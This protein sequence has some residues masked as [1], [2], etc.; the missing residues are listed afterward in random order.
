MK[1]KTILSI[2]FIL[3]MVVVLAAFFIVQKPDSMTIVNGLASLIETVGL[4]FLFT[5]AGTSIGYII[6]SRSSLLIE[7]TP[8]LLIFTGI[9]MGILGLAGFGLAVIGQAHPILLLIV[10]IAILTLAIVNRSLF[11]AGDDYRQLI[12]NLK[13]SAQAAQAWIPWFA[14]SAAALTFLL[15]LAPP[16][17]AFDALSYHLTVPT[18][19]LNNGGVQSVNLLQ[20]WFPSLME[21]MFVWPLAFGKDSAPQLIHF[22]FALLTIL[23]AWDWTRTLWSPKAAW[24]TIAIF[25]SMPSLM[26]LAAWAYSDLALA[27]Y[28]LSALYTLWKWRMDSDQRWLIICGAML[29]FAMGIK[30]TSVILLIAIFGLMIGWENKKLKSLVIHCL[31]M[32]IPGLLIASPWYLRNWIWMGNAFYPFIFGGRYWDTFRASW[33]SS[34]GTGIGWNPLRILSLPFVATLGYRDANYFDG[35]FGPFYLILFP[36]VVWELLRMKRE[37]IGRREALTIVLIFSALSVLFWTYGVIQTGSLW[38]AR[39]LWPGIIP[40]IVPMSVSMIGLEKIDVTKLRFSFIFSVL[41]ELTIFVF[42]LDFGLQVLSRDPLAVAIGLESRESYSA[43]EQPNYTGAVELV[44]QTPPNAYIY[45]I[46]EPRSYGMNRHIQ[47]DPINDNLPHDFYL[48]PANDELLSAWHELGYTHILLS[49][50]IMQIDNSDSTSLLIPGFY[51][52]LE[53]L[54]KLLKAEGQTNDGAYTLYSIPIH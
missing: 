9:G 11:L 47:P 37:Q 29:G 18:W 19:W 22:V 39:L 54:K 50:R 21:G 30:Y 28:S 27:F 31:W 42:L 17:E 23:M 53:N 40:L 33:L 7:S 20:Y 34:T 13:D 8:R 51:S 15:A 12:L 3:W 4:A 10:L 1:S 2:A 16:V 32:A 52:R 25:L 5:I 49:V 24:W 45:L 26:W 46:D 35:R 44:N 36:L 48:Y 14:V 41:M 43:R 6:F 38:Q